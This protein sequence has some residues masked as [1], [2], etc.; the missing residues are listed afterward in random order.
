MIEKAATSLLV[1]EI[2]D[3]IIAQAKEQQHGK[4]QADIRV[5]PERRFGATCGE[6]VRTFRLCAFAFIQHRRPPCD[7]A[8]RPARARH[9]QRR[10]E[11]QIRRT[12]P[13]HQEGDKQPH[14]H[15]R[16]FLPGNQ[17]TK[18]PFALL[19][20][21]EAPQQGPKGGI[22]LVVQHGIPDGQTKDKPTRV[23]AQQPDAIANHGRQHHQDLPKEHVEQRIAAAK[24]QIEQREQCRNQA[25]ADVDVGQR[26]R[27]KLRQKERIGG[28]IGQHI[29]GECANGKEQDQKHQTTLAWSQIQSFRY[30]HQEGSAGGLSGLSTHGIDKN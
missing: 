1:E 28:R 5:G 9:A 17:Q 22:Y 24:A 11:Q 26:L 30:P 15:R 27:I 3:N 29:G 18:E 12:D 10:Q 20:V 23:P 2:V 19:D 4:D 25:F 21:E 8:Q 6:R 16:H 13:A 14:A 7:L